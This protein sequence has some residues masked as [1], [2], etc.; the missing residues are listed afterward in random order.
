MAATAAVLPAVGWLYQG[1]AITA[2]D[3][4][5]ALTR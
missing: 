4:L 5:H 2:V 1:L 3:V